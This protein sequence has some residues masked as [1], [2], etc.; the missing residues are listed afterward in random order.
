MQNDSQS[1]SAL[2]KSENDLLIGKWNEVDQSTLPPILV[3]DATPEMVENVKRFCLSV[4]QILE[5]FLRR[6]SS[7][8]TKRAY[9]KDIMTLI[10]F[11]GIKWPEE[12]YRMFEIS[13]STVQTWF[14]S[15]IDDE[16][17]PKTINRRI[18]SVSSFFRFMGAIA[19]DL[20][21]P[22][23]IGNPA[24]SQFLRRLPADPLKETGSLSATQARQL[25]GLPCEESAVHYRDRAILKVFLYTGAR[26]GTVCDLMLS[27]FDNIGDCATLRL[28][29]KGSKTRTIGLHFAAAE[30]IQQYVDFC[31]IGP[32]PLFRPLTSPNSSRLANRPMS[33]DTMYRIVMGYLRMLPGSL[34]EIG[35]DKNELPLYECRY[36]PH[37]LRATTAT[38]LL[39]AG[40]DITKVQELLGHAHITTTS[41]YDKRRISK[42]E[43]AS[44]SV[45]I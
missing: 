44:H 29:E 6:V 2:T 13:V 22:I 12:S 31:N 35:R 34:I 24:H 16:K 28:R 10:E 40:E 37:S 4:D 18:S 7:S 17:A 1:P 8:E 9:R 38:L 19:A 11:V 26:L 39:Q 43:S 27:D 23:N 21:L 30:S 32:G 42:K 20:K 5:M 36:S 3:G 25:C 45:P 14:E 41:I 15:M 33:R